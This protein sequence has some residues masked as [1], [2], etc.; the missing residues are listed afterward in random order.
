MTLAKHA[1]LAKAEQEDYLA[2]T[3]RRGDR[4]KIIPSYPRVSPLLSGQNVILICVAPAEA[5]V[6]GI[7]AHGAQRFCLDPGL[8]RDDYVFKSRQVQSAQFFAMM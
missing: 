6:Q 5:G 8:R 3:R 4:K 2:E 1:K 7:G